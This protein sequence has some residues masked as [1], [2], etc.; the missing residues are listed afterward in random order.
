VP[1]WRERARWARWGLLT[2]LPNRTLAWDWA[3][4]QELRDVLAGPRTPWVVAFG[5]VREP[6][7]EPFALRRLLPLDPAFRHVG[8]MRATTAGWLL[9]DPRSDVVQIDIAAKP[10][11]EIVEALVALGYRLVFVEVPA[12]PWPKLRLVPSC[13][14]AA[15]AVMGLPEWWIVTP[16]QLWR[17]LRRKYDGRCSQHAD[18][19]C[20]G[21]A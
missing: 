15:V 14:T 2:F 13:V 12:H 3:P 10:I 9:V 4:T 8:L 5:P 19:D 1:T 6:W 11:A 7:R 20:E 21:S 16:R 17:L 18:V